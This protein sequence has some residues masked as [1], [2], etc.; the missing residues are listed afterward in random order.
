MPTCVSYQMYSMMIV[1]RS[2]SFEVPGTSARYS[3]T[4]S[5]SRVLSR[6]TVV[7]ATVVLVVLQ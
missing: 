7:R 3:T 1:S 4:G 5:Q 6:L 2:K